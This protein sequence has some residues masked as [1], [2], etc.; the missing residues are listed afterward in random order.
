[1]FERISLKKVILVALGCVAI[2]GAGV[3]HVHA[4]GE[5]GLIDDP[6]T[7]TARYEI[8]K[9]PLADEVGVAT[10]FSTMP[11]THVENVDGID[12]T[13]PEGTTL[14]AP[15]A[16]DVEVYD[17]PNGTIIKITNRYSFD[18][19]VVGYIDDCTVED[20]DIVH[21]G[22]PIGTVS[23]KYHGNIRFA[24]FPDNNPE[25]TSDTLET[26]VDNGS[27]IDL[28]LYHPVDDEGEEVM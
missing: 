7:E 17:L 2:I 3:A 19:C 20:G 13:Y 14:R 25:D 5:V 22:D 10:Y 6:I 8:Q 26:L 23:E 21:A 9:A 11:T 24:Y 15:M 12:I 4:E 1:M 18:S 28:S 16:G 27:K